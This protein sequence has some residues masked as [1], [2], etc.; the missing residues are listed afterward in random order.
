MPALRFFVGEEFS[1]IPLFGVSIIGIISGIA[2][3]VI[4]VLL[5]ART[6]AKRAAKVSPIAAVSG[7]S[8]NTKVV[9]HSSTHRF[10]S[11]LKQS[12]VFIMQLLQRKT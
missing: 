12:W 3:G 10:F 7:N 11:K 4:T 1:N 9:R 5:A 6:P 2:V 8:E